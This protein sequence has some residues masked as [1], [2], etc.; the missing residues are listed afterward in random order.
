MPEAR[1]KPRLD[2][3]AYIEG[4]LR[5]EIRHEYL[6]GQV[7]AM[8]GASDTHNIIAGNLFSALHV[9]LRGG[10][11]RAF[12]TDMK[13]RVRV[14]QDDYFYYPDLMVACS[15]EDSARYYRERPILIAEVTSE[16]TERID[17]RE[18]LLAYRHIAALEEYLLLA[19]DRVAATLYRR[20]DDWGS[21]QLAAGDELELAC[22]DFEAAL[23]S[24]YEGAPGIAST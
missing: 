6:A 15:P 10:P 18:K 11:C 9:H 3:D 22:L 20:A 19:Q 2:I 1:D 7:C 4:E 16:S 21:R 8:V 14:G 24:L 17:R 13:V 23:A 12:M 5:S